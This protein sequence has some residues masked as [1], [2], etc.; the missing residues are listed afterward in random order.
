MEVFSKLAVLL[1]LTLLAACSLEPP[2]SLIFFNRASEKVELTSIEINATPIDL[3]SVGR[4]D[5]HIE[6][7][8]AGRSIPG[9]SLYG[10]EKILVTFARDNVSWRA[11]CV[12]PART[13]G[14]CVGFAKPEEKRGL[15]CWFDCEG[16]VSK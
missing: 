5:S 4:Q 6:I 16:Q 15:A 9:V 3:V 11:S 7:N 10:S 13:S 12:F 2:S 1:L 14:A 8:S